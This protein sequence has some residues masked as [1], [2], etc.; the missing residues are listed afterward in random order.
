ML[1]PPQLKNLTVDLQ[2][3]RSLLLS[4]AHT[5]YIHTAVTQMTSLR[6]SINSEHHTSVPAVIAARHHH[7][8]S[9]ERLPC[10]IIWR[11][12]AIQQ[13]RQRQ[14]IRQCVEDAISPGQGAPRVGE[15]AATPVVLL[16]VAAVALGRSGGAAGRAATAAVAVRVHS[17]TKE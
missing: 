17:Y 3:E 15:R 6:K 16:V 2:I 7:L 13:I 11:R 12:L 14:S 9:V 5:T 8:Y 4:T 1:R 10:R